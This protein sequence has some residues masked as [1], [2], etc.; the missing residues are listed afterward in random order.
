MEEGQ[1]DLILVPLGVLVMA[2]YYSWL[3]RIIL[4]NPERTVIG[5]NAA[6]RERWVSFM[7]SDPL[8]NG[9][10]AVQTIRNNIMASTLLA[11]T[12]ITLSSI[13]G[14]FVSST[15]NPSISASELVYGNKSHLLSSIKYFSILLCFLVAFLCNVQSI[16]Y[17][18]HVSI[19]VTLPPLKDRRES[20]A[21]VARS[22]NRGSYFWSLGL[23]AF[24]VSFPLFLWIFG[25]IPMFV[26]CF[27]MSSTLYF[28]DTTTIFTRK[29]HTSSFKEVRE[30]NDTESV[31]QAS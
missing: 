31:P 13:I 22:F 14:V 7:M 8:K 17:Y 5:L 29:L 23:R 27:V 12:A 30:A 6:S 24:Y 28:L 16:R 9:V 18:S 25:P 19:L 4:R 20:I 26:C 3:L 15:T 1:L 10:L 11:T 2:I 21:Y